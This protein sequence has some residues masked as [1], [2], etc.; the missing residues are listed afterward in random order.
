MTRLA[1]T[2]EVLPVE[3]IRTIIRMAHARNVMVYVD[4]AGGA[5][6]GPSIFGQPKMLE[7]GVD[8]GATGLDK[9][10]TLGPRF[11]LMAGRKDLVSRIR[12]KG[13]EMGL[14]CRPMLYP[15]VVRTL[16]AYSPERIRD[17]VACTKEV[18]A[19]LKKVFGD[20]LFETPVTAQLH[21]DDVL[22]IAME[23]GK[24]TTAPIVPYE[25]T[26]ALC[27][28]MLQDYGMLTVH[29]VGMPPGGADL[30]IKF[31]PP[32]TLK[33]L[34][35]AAVFAKNMDSSMTKLGNMLRDPRQLHTL[36]FGTAPAATT[37]N[38]AQR[39]REL[40]ANK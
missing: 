28:L 38:E 2:Y 29:F 37:T 40:V 31:I 26:A 15:A 18:A 9:Y 36:F 8:V 25:A 17:L 19:E 16:D 27:M 13:F 33:K 1:V 12:A 34:G 10:G 35:G 24:V 6:V 22:A 39:E 21:A 23:R 3:D 4:D 20:R 30:L 7:L 32:E 5:R 11:G 14:E